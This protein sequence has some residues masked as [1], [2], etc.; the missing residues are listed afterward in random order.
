MV[1]EA[2]T[3]ILLIYTGS[4]DSYRIWDVMKYLFRFLNDGRIISVPAFF[5]FLIVSRHIFSFCSYLSSKRYKLL[6]D[7][8]QGV[9]PLPFYCDTLKNRL[10]NEL[11]TD[12]YI[13]M[14]FG[15]PLIEDCLQ[16]IEKKKISRI[17]VMPMY[18]HYSSSASGVPLERTIKG[19][20]KFR[21]IPE[22]VSINSFF[23]EKG[24][25][26]AFVERIK[27]YDYQNFDEI[28]FSYHSLPLAHVA[29]WDSSYPEECIE[30]T[31]LIC[32][33]LGIK[34]ATTG[35]QSQM[36][37]KWLGPATKSVIAEMIKNGKTRILV[38]APSFVSD[39]L[40][41]EIELNVELKKFFLDSG[42]KEL[43]LVKSLN[44]HP[45][46]IDF[47]AQKY[48]NLMK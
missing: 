45:A 40:E 38:V 47:I 18:P 1:K 21:V 2:R 12:V 6:A 20:S 7:I 32:N 26:S 39:C 30:T 34:T 16:A 10:R 31:R 17:M 22:I 13:G 48:R 9:F 43:Q 4:P 44:D 19:L 15:R 23:N 37:E 41:T 3:A 27:E 36:S 35:F 14:C 5:R 24:F 46:W 11:N 25:I 8:Y 42:G 29:K 28:I 33:E